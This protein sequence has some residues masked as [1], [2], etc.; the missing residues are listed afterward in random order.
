[1]LKTPSY[2]FKF[3]YGSLWERT[4]TN[5]RLY[6]INKWTNKLTYKIVK[7]YEGP[8]YDGLKL[9]CRKRDAYAVRVYLNRRK[10]TRNGYY[11]R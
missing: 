11:T 1:M 8:R 6:Y 7:R 10:F 2:E 5:I 4:I 3:P 9:T